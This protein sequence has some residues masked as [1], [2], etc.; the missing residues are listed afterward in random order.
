MQCQHPSIPKAIQLL[1]PVSKEYVFFFQSPQLNLWL[2]L[3]NSRS[4]RA[5][6]CWMAS[7]IQW[8]WTWAYSGTQ[9][10]TRETRHAAVHGIAKSQTRLSDWT[11]LLF[12]LIFK[13][14][15]R[16]HTSHTTGII[17]KSAFEFLGPLHF[18]QSHQS[19]PEGSPKQYWLR[20]IQS[21]VSFSNDTFCSKKVIIRE[22]SI[23]RGFGKTLK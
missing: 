5:W 17:T 22:I 12:K 1:S 18:K 15:W 21:P 7:P 6:D 11:T 16:S 19:T 20:S 23:I 13:K 3:F 14:G 4:I 10:G 9:W 2:L 8:T